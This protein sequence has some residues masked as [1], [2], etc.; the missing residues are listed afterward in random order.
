MICAP[1]KELYIPKEYMSEN[2]EKA[3][4]WLKAD[5]WKNIPQGKTEIDGTKLFATRSVYMSKPPAECRY[6]RH[7][8][9]ADIQLLIRGGEIIRVCSGDSLKIAEPYSGEKDIE[10]IEGGPERFH[11]VLLAFPLAAVFFPH[12]THMPCIA[13]EGGLG[14][15]EKVVVK[16]AL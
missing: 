12:D 8:L 10:F 16:V 13:P 9:Y 4:A 3:L 7:R 11:G 14:E 1:Y 6:E 15:V 5:S 2:W